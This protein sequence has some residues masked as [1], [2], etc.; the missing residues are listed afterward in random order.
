[1][2][3]WPP[4]GNFLLCNSEG[5]INSETG[6]GRRKP[7]ALPAGGQ[8]AV[9]GPVGCTGRSWF[10]YLCRRPSTDRAATM[11]EAAAR[12]K[13]SQEIEKEY[14]SSLADLN[15]NSKPLIN[16]LTILAEENV[17]YAQVIVKSVENHLA[18]VGPEVKLPILYLVDSIVKNVGK[19]YQ[20]LFSQ[21]IVNM[22]CGVF[23]TVRN[24]EGDETT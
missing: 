17:E 18:Q 19:Q 14:L 13:R 2:P 9:P 4:A 15:V 5:H 22:F 23:E 12:D 10:L 3:S 11:D 20:S 7:F 24:T 8:A 6:S 16:M 21:V 1:M